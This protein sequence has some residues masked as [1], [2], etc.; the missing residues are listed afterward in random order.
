MSTSGEC[1]LMSQGSTPPA[2]SI[3]ISGPARTQNMLLRRQHCSAERRGQQAA[4]TIQIYTRKP[5][6]SIPGADPLLFSLDYARQATAP[7]AHNTHLKSEGRS[8]CFGFTCLRRGACRQLCGWTTGLSP[9]FIWRHFSDS[10]PEAAPCELATKTWEPTGRR[11]LSSY[12]TGG[13]TM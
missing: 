12:R 3:C 10:K 7:A 5:L 1:K 9:S 4:I 2:I 13:P 8:H 6:N 11:F